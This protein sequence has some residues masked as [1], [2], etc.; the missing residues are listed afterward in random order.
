MYAA[1]R[2]NL[3][4]VRTER[5]DQ[6]SENR[7]PPNGGSRGGSGQT[8]GPL[9]IHRL[10]LRGGIYKRG[11]DTNCPRTSERTT[12]NLSKP[13]SAR[14]ALLCADICPASVQHEEEDACGKPSSRI[15]TT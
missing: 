1:I 9:V 3:K 14:G 12:I 8:C 7:A 11:A 2:R 15:D 13:P 4:P 5:A 10:L 6:T